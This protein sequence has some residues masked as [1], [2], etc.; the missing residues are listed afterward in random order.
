MTL[1]DQLNPRVQSAE[2][3]KNCEL[4]LATLAKLRFAWR[5]A[6][7]EVLCLFKI[8]AS[9]DEDCLTRQIPAKMEGRPRSESVSSVV[10]SDSSGGS[11]RMFST[12]SRPDRRVTTLRH[13]SVVAAMLASNSLRDCNQVEDMVTKCMSGKEKSFMCQTA[14]RY[15][16]KCN[17][18]DL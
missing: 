18:P 11:E 1:I 12:T 2:V 9:T 5:V 13:N 17:T 6:Y 4:E 15:F 10:S 14:H 8:F 7:S 16:A 3:L